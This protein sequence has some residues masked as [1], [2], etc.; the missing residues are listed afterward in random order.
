MPLLLEKCLG[1]QKGRW[2]AAAKDLM[3]RGIE[4]DLGMSHA[5]ALCVT[6]AFSKSYG[7]SELMKGASKE[8]STELVSKIAESCLLGGIP[9]AFGG[10]TG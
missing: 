10:Y 3:V 8:P 9:V 2:S 4:K 5:L 6:D 1:G 7:L